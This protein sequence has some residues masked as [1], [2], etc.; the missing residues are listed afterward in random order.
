[1]YELGDTIPLGTVIRNAAGTAVD[2]S[3]IA[4]TVTLPDATSASPTPVHAA[5][6]TYTY[7]YVP[8]QAG[9]HVAR[10]V[11]TTPSAAFT[12]T[13]DVAPAAPP[14]IVGL[15]E[16]K[17]FLNIRDT[18][19][20]QDEELR[21]MLEGVTA[22]VEFGNGMDWPGVGPVVR[23]QVAS[24]LYPTG[25]QSTMALPYANVL[26]IDSAAYVSDATSIPVT[27]WN[28]DGGV[29]WLNAG[30]VFPSYPFALTYTVGLP[31]LPANIRM[32]AL[33]ILKN[34]WATQRASDPAP[35]LVPRRAMEWLAPDAKILGFA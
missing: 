9:R 15:A 31:D 29:V 13:F 4:L 7:D 27:G 34:A 20:A 23:R 21:A 12:D 18:D 32:G 16:A 5:T 25:Y 2:P 17:A 26:T 24:T 30:T 22:V 8:T 35:F 10:W 33:E 11:S 1:L 19:T 14:L 3:T 6:G 28:V